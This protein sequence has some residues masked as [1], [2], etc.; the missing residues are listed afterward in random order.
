MLFFLKSPP[1]KKNH[2]HKGLDVALDRA[3]AV[4]GMQRNL[5][6]GLASQPAP[7]NLSLMRLPPTDP[8][9]RSPGRQ[10]HPPPAAFGAVPFHGAHRDVERLGHVFLR[11]HSPPVERLLEQPLYAPLAHSLVP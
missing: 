7:D 4:M 5:I 8:L 1:M 3:G 9:H 2:L 6:V 11:R 10:H